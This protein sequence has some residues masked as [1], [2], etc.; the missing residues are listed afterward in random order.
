MQARVKMW[1]LPTHVTQAN[2]ATV[3]QATAKTL[4]LHNVSLENA[5]A[6]ARP[7]YRAAAVHNSGSPT[8]QGFLLPHATVYAC[9][10]QGI[11]AKPHL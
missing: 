8:H 11:Q 5:T 2:R 3:R 9:L 6:F 1:M 7:S 10:F 4:K